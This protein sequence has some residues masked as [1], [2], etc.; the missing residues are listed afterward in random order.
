[1]L[2]PCKRAVEL[3]PVGSARFWHA[4]GLVGTGAGAAG[5]MTLLFEVVDRT[6]A[7]LSTEASP[8]ALYTAVCLAIALVLRGQHA[9]AE[10]ILDQV[11]ALP[12]ALEGRT[13]ACLLRARA[14]IALIHDDLEDHI[15]LAEECV[16]AADDSGDVRLATSTRTALAYGLAAMG[17][18]ERAEAYFRVALGHANRAGIDELA[19]G[20][21]HNLGHVLGRLG[22]VDEA[23]VEE[24]EALRFFARPGGSKRM[25]AGSRVYLAQILALRGERDEAIAELERAR[26]VDETPGPVLVSVLGVLSRLHT[27]CGHLAEGRS[28]AEKAVA[29]A[30][31]LGGLEEGKSLADLALAEACEANGDLEGSR[32]AIGKAKRELIER[33]D[34]LRTSA[35]RSRFLERIAENATIVAMAARLGV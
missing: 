17:E 28:V 35:A 23:L 11:E 26:V 33:A 10:P 7:A 24:R 34:R 21:R 25:E 1:M 16:V 4:L 19:A 6:R 32:A 12:M 14:S 8:A 30:R 29:I 9:R 22:K 27:A 15:R 5:D 18:L 3:L 13:R 2:E 20:A 31:E